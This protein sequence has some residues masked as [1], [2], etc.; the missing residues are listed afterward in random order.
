MTQKYNQKS[1][2]GLC[3]ISIESFANRTSSTDLQYK[4][5]ILLSSKRRLYCI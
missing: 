4:A 2:H 3:V 5:V 1:I